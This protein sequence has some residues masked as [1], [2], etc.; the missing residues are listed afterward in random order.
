MAH[1]RQVSSLVSVSDD[2]NRANATSLGGN[3][4]LNKGTFGIN[5]N[6]LYPRTASDDCAAFWNAASFAANQFAQGTITAIAADSFAIGVAVR[7]NTSAVASFYFAYAYRNV[8]PNVDV[9]IGKYVSG[10]Y[11]SLTTTTGWV[12]NDVLR[13]EISGTT[14]TLKRNGST[15]T[16]TS[17]SSLSSGSPGIS[18]YGSSS[19]N[20]KL[21]NWS[22]G[23]L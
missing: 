15:L 17:D 11:T 4:T 19:A 2:F 23:D 12:V 13:L 22:G 16:T 9:E 7:C 20:A 1:W 10:T 14:L 18:G 8:S 21:D 3:W 5:T 6:A